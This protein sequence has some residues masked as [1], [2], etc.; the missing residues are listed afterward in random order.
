VR[1]PVLALALGPAVEDEL[2]GA[3]ELAAGLAAGA[4]ELGVLQ[5]IRHPSPV[6]PLFH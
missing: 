4:A 6:A 1:R 3:L 2:A 5:E